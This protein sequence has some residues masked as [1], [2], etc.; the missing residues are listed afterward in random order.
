RRDHE[1]LLQLR[2]KTARSNAVVLE[3]IG[4]L[5]DADMK[6]P[7]NVLFVCKLNPVTTDDD[8]EIIFTRHEIH[9]MFGTCRAEICRDHITGDS[10]N[11]AFV[12]FEAIESCEEVRP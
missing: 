2:E 11:Y 10:L 3:M 7:E 8:L 4:D 1:W 5:P 12:E 9:P 6:P